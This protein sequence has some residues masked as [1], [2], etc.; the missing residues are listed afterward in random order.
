MAIEKIDNSLDVVD[1]ILTKTTRI[2]IELI[3]K[4]IFN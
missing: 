4:F 1:S 3:E 2:I